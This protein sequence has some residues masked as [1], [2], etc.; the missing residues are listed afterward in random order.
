M[1][2]A[3]QQYAVPDDLKPY[4][5]S[6]WQLHYDDAAS[7]ISPVQYCLALGSIEIIVHTTPPFTHSGILAG[8]QV[9]FP[10]A[11]IGGIHV[12]PML[13]RMHGGT[14]MFGISC[15]PEMFVTLF[16]LP[17]GD[18]VDDYA[19]LGSFFGKCIGDLPVQLQ[20]APSAEHRVQIAV[21]FFRRRMATQSRRDRLYFSEAMHYI[22]MESGQQSVD[23]ICGKVFVGKRQLQRVF[24]ENIGI[25][26]KLY[27][28][29]VR[30][31]GAYNYVQRHPNA[32]WTEISHHFGYSDQSH[33]IRDFREFTG[34]NPTA[35]LSLYAPRESTPLALTS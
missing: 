23:D 3:V 14:G 21:D 22:R 33:F 5:D 6:F 31:K 35:F 32:T 19:D 15:K 26:P 34:E 2:I 13:F 27:G 17:V 1:K 18:L 29:I 11:F 9:D 16:D 28:R 7:A 10:E 12:E 8:R 20:A 24:Q 25:S 4:I 30:F